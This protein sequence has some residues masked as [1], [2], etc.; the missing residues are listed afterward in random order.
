MLKLK[1]ANGQRETY[2]FGAELRKSRTS[3]QASKR[4]AANLRSELSCS[5]KH[6]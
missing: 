2:F 4:F 6:S 5:V 1:L 3:T